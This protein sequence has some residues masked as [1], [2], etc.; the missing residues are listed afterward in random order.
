MADNRFIILDDEDHEKQIWT[1]K[2]LSLGRLNR[3]FE[4]TEVTPAFAQTVFGEDP[5]ELPASILALI[6]PEDRPQFMSELG[7]VVSGAA[8]LERGLA[9]IVTRDG[10]IMAMEIEAEPWGTDGAAGALISCREQYAR[11]SE[12]FAPAAAQAGDSTEI[13]EIIRSFT[14][15]ILNPV[16]LLNTEGRII[17]V[18]SQLRDLLGMGLAELKSKPVAVILEKRKDR[19]KQAMVQFVNHMRKGAMHDVPGEWVRADGSTIPVTMSGSLIRS[20]SGELIG[21][22]VVGRDES[23]NAFLSHLENKNRELEEAYEELKRLDLMKDDFLSLVGH[24]L[25]APLANI[26][27]YAEFLVEWELSEEERAEYGRIIYVESQRLKRLVNDILDLSRMEA[28][29]MSYVYVRDSV[30]RVVRAAADS[31]RSD[32]ERKEIDFKLDL[33]RHLDTI[34]FDPDRVQQVVTNII[35]NAIKFTDAGKSITVVTR[36]NEDGIEIA[37]I[38]QG[39]GIDKSD[40]AKIFDKFGQAI[41]VRHHS[42]GAG[43][44]MAIARS[45]VTDGHGGQIWFES[46]GRDKGTTFRFTIPERRSGEWEA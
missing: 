27:G 43:L 42:E 30:N 24:E 16:I 37:V 18:N 38:D 34:E 25:R 23:E 33:F 36:P 1:S 22:V 32:L 13:L 8:T 21:M 19:M 41:D 17:H 40:K 45:I 28:G 39:V 6:H 7:R 9:R 4:L 5:P 2:V 31:L 10:R 14:A 11:P 15:S 26:L 46:G 44:G 35:H 29:R 20:P 12:D 3:E